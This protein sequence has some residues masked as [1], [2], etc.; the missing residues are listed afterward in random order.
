MHMSLLCHILAFS[1]IKL[2]YYQVDSYVL[3]SSKVSYN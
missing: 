3:I 2:F 1:F